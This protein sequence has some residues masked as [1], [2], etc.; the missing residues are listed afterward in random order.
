[1]AKPSDRDEDFRLIQEREAKV[2]F[3]DRLPNYAYFWYC[4]PQGN[5]RRCQSLDE[6]SDLN[7]KKDSPRIKSTIIR[8]GRTFVVSTVFLG[9]DHN[10]Y[11]PTG[12]DP[13]LFETMIFDQTDASRSFSDLYCDRY[14]TWL[15]AK[16]GHESTVAHLKENWRD[17][18]PEKRGG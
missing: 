15:E 3:Q 6:I 12:A 11:D 14:R 8:G 7:W 18:L 4:D 10:F 5:Y 16:L 1:M 13:I 2:P 9:I 17:Y